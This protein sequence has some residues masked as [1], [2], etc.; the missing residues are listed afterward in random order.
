MSKTKELEALLPYAETE[1]Q[2]A[3]LE[4]YIEHG[5]RAEACVSLGITMAALKRTMLQ[6]NK[7]ARNSGHLEVGKPFSPIEGHFIKGE[8]AL[9]DS[10]G[11]AKLRWIKTD[12]DKRLKLE[13]LH[14]AIKEAFED[15]KGSS[16]IHEVPKHCD[17][18]LLCVI[19]IGDPHAGL[20]AWK[21]DTGNTFNLDICKR[22][23][24]LALARLISSAPNAKTC[25]IAD[26]GDSLH[27]TSNQNKTQQS[28]NSLDCDSRFIKSARTMVD[29]IIRAVDLALQKFQEV[30][31]RN[32]LGNHGV[33]TEQMLALTLDL[34]YEDNPRVKVEASTNKFYYYQHGETLIGFTHGDMVKHNEL[35]MIMA[36]DACEMWGKTKFRYWYIGHIHSQHVKEFQ[37][38]TV[39]SF[40]TL[41]GS[42][43]WHHSSGYRSRKNIKMLIIHKKYGEIER[44][45]K[46]VS[47]IHDELKKDM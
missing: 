38:C 12:T 29:I 26:L 43:H 3:R 31:V 18:D 46:D 30:I 7:R 14:K 40:N 25:I 33:E 28:G 1:K 10:Q 27:R 45:I 24:N 17:E 23:L 13:L 16:I 37:G 34:Y 11:V 41:A 32:C 47:F 8:S 9:V 22:D 4:A 15:F 2:K 5:S 19:P 21:E 20:L 6:I 35:P 44:T 42:D 39:E 36:S